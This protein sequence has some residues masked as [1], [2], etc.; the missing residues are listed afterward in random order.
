MST[1]SWL[2]DIWPSTREHGPLFVSVPDDPDRPLVADSPNALSF[3]GHVVGY[4]D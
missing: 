2:V 1:G 4:R 3:N